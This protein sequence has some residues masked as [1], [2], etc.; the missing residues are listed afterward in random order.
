MPEVAAPPARCTSDVQRAV[1]AS[2]RV[3]LGAR[4]GRR[5][6]ATSA[7]GSYSITEPLCS[8]GGTAYVLGRGGWTEP[9]AMSMALA[10]D[11]ARPAGLTKE[12]SR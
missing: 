1:C 8:G 9:S 12:R 11:P 5:R 3:V 4:S 10:E 7:P 6:V 2:C